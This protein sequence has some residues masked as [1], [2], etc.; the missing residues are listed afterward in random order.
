MIPIRYDMIWY[1]ASYG[2][3]YPPGFTVSCPLHPFCWQGQ[4]RNLQS[5]H[6]DV[7]T[8]DTGACSLPLSEFQFRKWSQEMKL[9]G[10]VLL[11]LNS[12]FFPFLR[13]WRIGISEAFW[14]V[15]GHALVPPATLVTETSGGFETADHNESCQTA[16][17]KMLQIVRV[18]SL[19]LVIPWSVKSNCVKNP[20]FFAKLCRPEIATVNPCQNCQVGLARLRGTCV[21]TACIVWNSVTPGCLVRCGWWKHC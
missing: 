9:Q 7:S 19:W 1:D 21:G 13:N 14:T 11:K 4:L 6:A 8:R 17:T 10:V 18:R 16:Q 5:D 12:S 3:W 2:R 20:P 15:T